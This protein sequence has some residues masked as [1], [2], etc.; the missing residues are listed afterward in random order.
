VIGGASCG[1]AVR[2]QRLHYFADGGQADGR[3]DT[4]PAKLGWRDLGMTE[5]QAVKWKE[6][7][8]A[9]IL[10]GAKNIEAGARP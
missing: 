2:P 9:M 10:E 5:A 4:D 6:E 3:R 8:R 1:A 7:V